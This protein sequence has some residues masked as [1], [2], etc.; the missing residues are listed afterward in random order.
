MFVLE[1][2]G[3]KSESEIRDGSGTIDHYCLDGENYENNMETIHKI[4]VPVGKRIV[5]EI[6]QYD[7]EYQNNCLYDFLEIEN[8]VNGKRFC[9]KNSN[10]STLIS[11][12]NTASVVF[13]TDDDVTGCGFYLSWSTVPENE[14]LII[15]Y[16]NETSGVVSSIHFPRPFPEEV[17]KCSALVAPSGYR[18]VLEI[19]DLRLPGINCSDSMLSFYSGIFRHNKTICGCTTLDRM[20]YMDRFYISEEEELNICFSAKALNSGEGFEAKFRYGKYKSIEFWAFSV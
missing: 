3:N 20:S 7:I 13:K 4:I 11:K 6:N 16:H 8:V 19:T 18:I 12:S 1:P 5:F 9:G 10:M 15:Q 2:L 14:S 17:H